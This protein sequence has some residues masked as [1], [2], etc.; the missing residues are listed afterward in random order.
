MEYKLDWGSLATFKENRNL[1]V[2]RW[3]YYKEG[4]SRGLVEKFFQLLGTPENILDPFCGV[5]TTLL[6]AKEVGVPSA[7]L[8]VL[9]IA[10][11]VAR[12]KVERYDP[13]EAEHW[14]NWFIHLKPVPLSTARVKDPLV[15]KV[16]LPKTL[17]KIL[18]YLDALE[19]V[20]EK[21]YR[22]L[23]KL[24][25]IN[26]ALKCSFAF[27]DGAIVKVRKRPVPPIRNVIKREGKK[28]LADIRVFHWSDTPASV[29]E[30]DARAMPFHDETFSAIFTSPPYLN[31]IE[32]TSVYR[33]EHSLFFPRK[34]IPPLRSYMGLAPEVPEDFRPDLPPPARGYLWD[35]RRVLEES[36]RVLKPGGWAVFV[37]GNAYLADFNLFVDVDVELSKMAEEVGFEVGKII[38]LNER[39]ATV[40]RTVKVGKVRESAVV[41]RKP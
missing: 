26:A 29:I 17:G 33:I 38:V 28:F 12:V 36:Y 4:F 9:P 40:R 21:K 32:Y 10:L 15:R 30:G 7:G 6:Y 19:K 31:K 20:E 25:L 1:P 37:V 23:L 22:N 14:I 5:G 8:D 41:L 24:I 35:M 18:W 3:F 34:H 16:F 27:K 2:Y 13:D 39:W 11:F